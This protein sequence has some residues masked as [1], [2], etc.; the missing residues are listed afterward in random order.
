MAEKEYQDSFVNATIAAN[1]GYID[2]IIKPDEV[3]ER[4]A[5][6]FRML[7]TKK[8]SNLPWKKHG[9]MPL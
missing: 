5:S 2:E 6:D 4:I 1:R 9:T 3:R 8:V 7:E